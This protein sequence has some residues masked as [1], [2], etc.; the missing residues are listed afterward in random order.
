MK[1]NRNVGLIVVMLVTLTLSLVLG[2]VGRSIAGEKEDL[3]TQL[4]IAILQVEKAQL[5]QQNAG[6]QAQMAQDRLQELSKTIQDKGF[7]I[8]QDKQTG[9]VRV[10]DKPKDEPKPAPE[11]KAPEKP[12]TTKK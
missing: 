2:V 12:D 5:A 7:Q 1:M 11:K 9:Q 10:V 4:A 3:Q 6:L 8:T